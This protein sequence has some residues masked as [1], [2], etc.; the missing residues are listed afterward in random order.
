[1][2][3]YVN[4]HPGTLVVIKST[5]EKGEAFE[6]ALGYISV[7]IN[8]ENKCQIFELSDVIFLTQ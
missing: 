5:N 6:S 7:F 2:S 8:G 4:Y 3:D 1:M